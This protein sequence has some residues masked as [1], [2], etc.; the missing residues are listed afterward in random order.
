MRLIHIQGIFAV[1]TLQ[2][3]IIVSV[4]EIGLSLLLKHIGS[5]WQ[6]LQ[7]VIIAGSLW[8]QQITEP[9]I[10]RKCEKTDCHGCL[11]YKWA[12]CHWLLFD[13]LP[14]KYGEVTFLSEA[15]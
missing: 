10:S 14:M 6:L 5:A 11:G 3:V 15:T 12:L 7:S 2:P 8:A 1:S 4:A 13:R 9:A